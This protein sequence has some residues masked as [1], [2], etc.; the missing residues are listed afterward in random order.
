MKILA[1]V[2][3]HGSL[4]ALNTIV[5]KTKKE[6]PD[7]LVCAGDLSVF[8]NGIYYFVHRLSR[9]KKPVLLI[10]GNH[11]TEETI[12][13]S[14]SLFENTEFIHK[15]I[16]RIGSYAFI[17]YGGGGFSREDKE[18]EKTAKKLIK[19][20][21]KDDK[22]ILVTHAPPYKTRLDKINGN[23]A[24]NKSIRHFI[25]TNNILLA[26]SGHL[27]DN[28]GKQDKIGKTKIINPGPFGKIITI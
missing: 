21:K 16:F 5:K 22:V 24:G 8:E 3:I 7:L 19:K 12:K 28:A 17:G 6:N 4:K 20:T 26:V 18:F 11:E 13:Q 25:E 9:L 2:D 23:Y 10:H 14:C 27:H 15:K 1:F